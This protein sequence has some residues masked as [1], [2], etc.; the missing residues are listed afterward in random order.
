MPSTQTKATVANYGQVFLTPGSTAALSSL[1]NKQSLDL[2]QIFDQGGK[3]VVK[4]SSTGVV[5]SNPATHTTQVLFNQFFTRLASTATLANIF[6][7][8]WSENKTQQDILQVRSQGQK[9]I[10][11]LDYLGVA[12]SS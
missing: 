2:L 8:V 12:Y 5:S 4:V 1:P 7:D 10:W 9:T 3:C 11:H 6:A